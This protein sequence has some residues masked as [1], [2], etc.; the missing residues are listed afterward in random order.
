MSADGRARLGPG[1]FASGDAV[2]AA[3]REGRHDP[4]L[5]GQGKA[6]CTWCDVHVDLAQI[7]EAPYLLA[8]VRARRCGT[9]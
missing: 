2:L 4:W 3:L 9:P 5:D 8:V 1:L 7:D 6:R